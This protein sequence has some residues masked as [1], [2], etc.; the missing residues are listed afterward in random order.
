MD[1]EAD[2]EAYLAELNKMDVDGYVKVMQD[3]YD[4]YKASLSK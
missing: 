3:A 2:W 4:A 1:I